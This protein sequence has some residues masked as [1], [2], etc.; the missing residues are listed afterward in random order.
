MP[1]FIEPGW[2]SL[3]P[4]LV[5][6]A[7]ALISRE[8]VLSLFAGVWM[9]AV[10]LAGFNP[11]TG[12][13]GS[14]DFLIDA[15]IDRDHMAIVVFSLLLG[16]MV[17]VMARSGGTQGIVAELEKLATN[18]TRGQFLTWASAV[19]IF[20]DDYANTL[21]RGNALR[22]MT[23]RLLISREKLAYIVDSTA[24][25]LAVS[26]VVTTWIG[27]Q[28]TQVRDAMATL[29]QNETDPELAAQL[30]AGADNA[31]LMVLHSIPYL[32]YPILAL[33]F[34]L[35]IIVMKKDFGPMYTAERRARS[36]GGLVRPGSMPASDPTDPSLQPP[37]GAPHRWY[38]A[39]VPVLVV[40]GVALASLWGT[41][42]A[43]LA[44]GER[45]IVAVIG[46]ADPFAS[47]LWASFAGSAVAIGLVVAQGILSVKGALEAWVGGIQSMLLAVIIL[48]LA[49]GLGGVTGDMGTGP[50]LASLLGDTLPLTI[51][52][53]LVFIVAA[54]TAFSTG[55]SW[56]TMAILFPVVIPLAVA[57]GAGVGFAGGE[58]YAILL[59][60]I[61][62][63][64][65]GAVF[66]DHS[67]PI[68]DTTV[69]S[70]MASACDLVD[71]VRTQLPYAL[72]VAV[73]ALAVG[74]IPAAAEWIHPVF[75]I[76]IGLGLLYLVLRFFGK[77]PEDDLPQLTERALDPTAPAKTG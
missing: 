11:I 32:F 71:H 24:A 33:F 61:S 31:F 41:G 70:S 65:A 48:V 38:N 12:T 1:Q 49:W 15:L 37:E 22:P 34:V 26:A 47:L 29:A 14:L 42:A 51:L 74:E 18:R 68:S 6:I 62:S 16:G 36:G 57:M 20:F 10:I 5:A 54:L 13:A 8:V 7:L 53:G 17:G 4:P 77:D 76:L 45:S 50:F 66:G 52:P 72:V 56:G 46:N 55:T 63:V 27:F 21:I 28:I 25:P 58:H 40:I 35:M 59:G 75:S 9:G 43:G 64:M 67:S 3:V 23:D 73:V 30:Q 19:F 44:A 2:L 39:A 60:T 69:L